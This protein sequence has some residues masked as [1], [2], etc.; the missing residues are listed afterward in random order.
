LQDIT[1]WVDFTRV[2]EASCA[3]G[4][5]LAGFTTQAM[6]L[7]GCGIDE[8]MQRLAGDDR[9][10]FARLASEARQLL[11]PGEMGERFKAMAWLRNLDTDL[12]GFC[13]R[14]LRHSL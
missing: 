3:C 1:A 9:R 5:E 2:A 4:F 12:R 14:D 11:L 8:E 13:L 7:A 6:F 10:A